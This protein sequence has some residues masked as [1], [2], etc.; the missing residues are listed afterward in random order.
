[1]NETSTSIAK[2]REEQSAL[3][4]RRHVSCVRTSFVGAERQVR[5]IDR[6]WLRQCSRADLRYFDRRGHRVSERGEEDTAGMK[7]D[8]RRVVGRRSSGHNSNE[9]AIQ[10]I[11]LVSG[12]DAI[13]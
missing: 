10:V 3:L 6:G 5:E 4:R 13:Y 12:F 2:R 7:E 1:V 9:P 8:D 11:C